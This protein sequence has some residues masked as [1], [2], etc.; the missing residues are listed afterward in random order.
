MIDQNSK[1]LFDIWIDIALIN[2]TPTLTRNDTEKFDQY[3][4][5]HWNS[6]KFPADHVPSFFPV[7]YSGFFGSNHDSI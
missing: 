3:A 2:C 1:I 7:T 6:N 4:K 5:H